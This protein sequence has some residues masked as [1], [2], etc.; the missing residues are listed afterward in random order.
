MWHLRSQRLGL[1]ERIQ[2][3]E[4]GK[5]GV[6]RKVR[7]LILERLRGNVEAGVLP[8]LQEVSLNLKIYEMDMARSASNALGLGLSFCGT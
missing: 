2:F 6:A 3:P 4:D 7:A 8:R 5:M 1:G